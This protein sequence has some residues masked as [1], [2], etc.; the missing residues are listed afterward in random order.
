MLAAGHPISSNTCAPHRAK[1]RVA[2]TTRPQPGR[3][4]S[5]RKRLARRIMAGIGLKNPV[6]VKHNQ[7][8]NL[9]MLKV[10]SP[11]LLIISHFLFTA[12]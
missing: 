6:Q 7:K 5:Q 11:H 2:Q 8:S 4:L 12:R 3:L 9:L 1:L 10:Q